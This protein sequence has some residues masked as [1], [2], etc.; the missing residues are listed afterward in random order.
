[1]PRGSSW[2]VN[3]PC[4]RSWLVTM[5]SNVDS[6]CV[7]NTITASGCSLSRHSA[8][9]RCKP[10]TR[11]ISLPSLISSL[12]SSGSMIVGT[13]ATRAAPTISPILIPPIASGLPLR[14]LRPRC[15]ADVLHVRVEVEAV[16]APLAP[17][18]RGLRAAERRPQVAHEEAVH[19]DRAGDQAL[20]DPFGAL[21]VTGV[22]DRGQAVVGLVRERDRLLLVLERLERED[23][24]EHLLAQHLGAL[25]HV[26]E[27]RR[28]VEQAAELLVRPAAEQDLGAVALRALHEPVDPRD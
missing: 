19:P 28:P 2:L 16:D 1:M 13:C 23:G 12:T 22:Q 9:M 11:V 26:A 20:G 21:A 14:S 5:C 10:G 18:P 6:Q 17:D 7:S 27:Q 8:L 25:G 4:R 15:R 24:S 3:L